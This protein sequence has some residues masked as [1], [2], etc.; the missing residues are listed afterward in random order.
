MVQGIKPEVSKLT[1]KGVFEPSQLV[2]QYR[3]PLF[4]FDFEVP[5]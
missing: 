5:V 3:H 2:N 1:S 4:Y